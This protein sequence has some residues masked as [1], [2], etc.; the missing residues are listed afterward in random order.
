LR[1]KLLRK[2]NSTVLP[3]KTPK[4]QSLEADPR[5]E[6]PVLP[7]KD[8]ALQGVQLSVYLPRWLWAALEEISASTV[9]PLRPGDKKERREYTRN[10][11]I[12]Y[13]LR[14]RVAAWRAE[15]SGEQKK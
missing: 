9:L 12:E 10:E 5:E 13:F 4:S 1:A 6:G 3:K 14:N 15:Q 11:V 2:K 7:R 8:P